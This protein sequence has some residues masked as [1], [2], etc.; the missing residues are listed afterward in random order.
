MILLLSTSTTPYLICLSS[1]PP[2][3]H[4]PITDS[5]VHLSTYL[6]TRR[7]QRRLDVDCSYAQRYQAFR[8]FTHSRNPNLKGNTIGL[9]STSIIVQWSVTP[10]SGKVDLAL[11]DESVSKTSTC[12]VKRMASHVKTPISNFAKQTGESAE[13]WIAIDV[14]GRDDDDTKTVK[15]VRKDPP[16]SAAIKNL[17]CHSTRLQRRCSNLWLCMAGPS[18]TGDDLFQC[19]AYILGRIM[20]VSGDDTSLRASTSP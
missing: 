13:K 4:L 10:A 16:G 12:S 17:Y 7:K 6:H 20:A 2:V 14:K 15:F 9:R 5:L 1:P 8:Q 18:M 11:E 19:W 3:V